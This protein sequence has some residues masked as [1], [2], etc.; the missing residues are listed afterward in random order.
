MVII[1]HRALFFVFKSE[2]L[3]LE[4]AATRGA[5]FL[6]DEWCDAFS[7]TGSIFWDMGQTKGGAES[8]GRGQQWVLRW[9]EWVEGRELPLPWGR[10]PLAGH[11]GRKTS[12]SS[13]WEGRFEGAAPQTEPATLVS[14]ISVWKIKIHLPSFPIKKMKLF[15]VW[16]AI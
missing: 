14:Y 16:S 5:L 12:H 13:D 8:N 9:G 2:F 7:S 4:N 1:M 3:K 10:E 11:S 15:S 6:E